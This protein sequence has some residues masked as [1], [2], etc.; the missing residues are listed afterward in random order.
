MADFDPL[1]LNKKMPQDAQEAILFLIRTWPLFEIALTDWLIAL[2][3]MDR[4]IG[5]LMVGRMD[6][7]SKINRLKEIYAHLGDKNQVQWLKNLDK[8][9]KRYTSIRNTVVHTMYM[10][11]R[12]D[13]NKPEEC[14]LIFSTHRPV[15]GRRKSIDAVIV[16]PSDIKKT[17]GF[18][19]RVVQK[20]R[21]AL[22]RHT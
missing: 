5:V 14:Q 19:L 18:A 1:A 9:A 15:R 3:R 21:E 17:A 16:T 10:G 7:G 2:T 22:A 11:H 12:A 13:P 4:E 6:T 8:S 20:I